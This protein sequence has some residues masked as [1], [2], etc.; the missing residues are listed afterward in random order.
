MKGLEFAKRSENIINRKIG[1]FYIK[2]MPNFFLGSNEKYFFE[3]DPKKNKKRP[4]VDFGKDFLC[5]TDSFYKGLLKSLRLRF[6]RFHENR[7]SV[8]PEKRF[9]V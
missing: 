2:A 9:W 4:K 7:F 3:R 5:K 1:C 8:G 6:L